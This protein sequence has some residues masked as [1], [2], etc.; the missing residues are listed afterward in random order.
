MSRKILLSAAAAVLVISA[1]SSAFARGYHGHGHGHHRHGGGGK[2]AAIAL[3]VIGGVIILNEL[4]ESRAR[5]RAYDDRYYGARAP[6]RTYD[7]RYYND[8]RYDDRYEDRYEDDAYYG[9]DDDYDDYAD[10]DYDYDDDEA[11]DG[12]GLAG[13]GPVDRRPAYEAPGA[14]YDRALQPISSAAAYRICLDHARRALGERGFVVAAPYRPDTVEDRGA[15]LLMTATVRAQRGGESWARAMSCE[16]S[17][18]RVFR[19][20]LI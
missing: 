15:A 10:D 11:Y 20:E 3:G 12:S 17:E 8:R 19:M 18:S 7:D 13:G 4:S 9:A 6:V 2:G 16:A 14:G 5:E 1:G